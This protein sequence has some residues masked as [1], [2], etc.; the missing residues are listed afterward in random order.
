M[1]QSR[2]IT[3]FLI[4][5]CRGCQLGTVWGALAFC[6]GVGAQAYALQHLWGSKPDLRK[7][8]DHQAMA[9]SKVV[10]QGVVNRKNT[11]RKALSI[12]ACIHS[13]SIAPRH[14]VR[15]KGL[16]ANQFHRSRCPT[17]EFNGQTN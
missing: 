5:R 15:A 9:G 14:R 3:A 13:V 2:A 7:I 16:A 17:A 4:V 8:G 11:T 10:R 1:V 12:F 6:R